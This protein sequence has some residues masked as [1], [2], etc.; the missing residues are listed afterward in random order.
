[1]SDIVLNA[2]PAALD[3]AHIGDIEGA[4]GTIYHGDLRRR[5]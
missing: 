3:R 4:L 2:G 5:L 1:M